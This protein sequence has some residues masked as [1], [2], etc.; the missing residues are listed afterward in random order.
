MALLQA[1]VL[2]SSVDRVLPFDSVADRPREL[3]DRI[4]P[5]VRSHM[6]PCALSRCASLSALAAL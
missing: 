6:A 2:G 5:W 4:P 3:D 1:E